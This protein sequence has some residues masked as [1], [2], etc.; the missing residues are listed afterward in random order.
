[1]GLEVVRLGEMVQEWEGSDIRGDGMGLGK[2]GKSSRGYI[3]S[4]VRCNEISR[5][6]WG[7]PGRV[8]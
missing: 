6:V 8:E 2:E 7:I 3:V 5:A 1:M 4:D